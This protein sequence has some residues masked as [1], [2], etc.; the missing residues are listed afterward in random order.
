VSVRGLHGHVVRPALASTD[1]A[2]TER[3]RALRVSAGATGG[4][5]ASS[6]SSPNDPVAEATPALGIA[7]ALD[8]VGRVTATGREAASSVAGAATS[9]GAVTPGGRRVNAFGT[10]KSLILKIIKKYLW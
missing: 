8:R 3:P 1:S 10:I 7:V 9:A 5:V 4:E 2:S 6:G